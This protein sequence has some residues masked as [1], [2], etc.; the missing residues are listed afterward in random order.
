MKLRA[1]VIDDSRVMRNMVMD[2][3]CKTGIADFEFTEAA[4]GGE[5]I[6]KFD[7][8]RI[9][10]P[11][12]DWNMPGLN[13]LEFARHVRSLRWAR[14]V[15]LIMITSES[16]EGKKQ[17]AYDK[18]RITCYI[19]KPFTVE[20]MRRALVPIVYEMFHKHDHEAKPAPTAAPAA[21]PGGGFFSKL[22]KG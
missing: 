5:A 20:T 17:D 15:P 2:S 19:T 9:D 7:P 10:I 1:L 8:D 21:R 13:G 11:F 16:A 6:S 3:L 18:A 12:V 14:H 22:I 4:D